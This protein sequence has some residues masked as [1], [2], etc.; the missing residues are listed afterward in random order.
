MAD[1]LFTP[2]QQRVLGLLFGQ[3]ARRFQSAEVIRLAGSG[4]GA[5]H[6]VLARL[7]ASGL[8]RV[9]KQGRQKF[10]QA[11]PAAPIH[12]E[13]VALVRKTVG[14]AEPLRNALE[15][16]RDRIAA[17][18]VYGSVAA[19]TDRGDSDVDLMIVGDELD[20]PAVY[21]A[22]IGAEARLGRSV[23]PVLMDQAT[24]RR[25]VATEDGLYERMLGGPTLFLIGG[26]DELRSP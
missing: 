8:V 17:A 10:Y 13:L 1:A 2:V 14:I 26:E 11:N 6:R 19:G 16:M 4:T 22:L 15:P 9:E 3:P 21:E 24:W 25:K 18:F 12:E 20:Y 7:E 5:T 23:H